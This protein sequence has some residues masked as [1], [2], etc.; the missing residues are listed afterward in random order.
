MQLI[1]GPLMPVRVLEENVYWKQ[2]E[3]QNTG[4]IRAIVPQLEDDYMHLLSQWEKVLA[5]T[6]DA[7][8]AQLHIAL[9]QPN[10][11]QADQPQQIHELLRASIY[12]SE[13]FIQQLEVMRHNSPAVQH[14]PCVS[15]VLDHIVSRSQY[16]LN[17]VRPIV[18][19]PFSIPDS[20]GLIGSSNVKQQ[21]A[22]THPPNLHSQAENSAYH[23]QHFQ[24]IRA[25]IGNTHRLQPKC[26]ADS[27]DE[28]FIPI[29]GHQLPPLPYPYH[30]LQPYID[31]TTMQIHH[32]KH[33]Q[34][35]V[36][37]LNRAELAL[38]E[39]RK[40]RNFDMIKYWENE[41]A[42]NG[43]GHYLHTLFWE[44]MIPKGGGKPSGKLLQQ[45][46]RDF[47]SFEAFKQQF[48][49]AAEKV[50]G[51]GWTILVWSPRSRRLEILQ[52]EKHQNLSQW[53]IVP[54]LP[55]DV[56][57]HAYYLNY[58]NERAKY[59]ENWWNVVNWPAVANRYKQA[60]L[61]KWTPY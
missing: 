57:E 6:E 12:Q 19:E 14:T 37:G 56:W 49:K 48:T 46:E 21:P 22:K 45:I 10:V 13:Q 60:Q 58:Q 16:F 54:L 18:S 9:Q 40:T 2:Q 3:K 38:A 52:A 30:A 8:H 35:Y 32:D 1:Y 26:A 28:Q 5:Q 50:E 59:V 33:H 23:S 44:V 53:D 25:Q 51:G 41:L 27:K 29:G 34:S 20:N 47:G 7:A 17:A 43:A 4:I 24:D 55:L 11:M 39:A 42:F 31:E 36:D 15:V 61:L